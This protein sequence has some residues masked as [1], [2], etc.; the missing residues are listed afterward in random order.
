MKKLLVPVDFSEF[1]EYA[2]EV[3]ASLAKRHNAEISVF[4][5]LGISES[6]FVANE[7]A[8]MAEAKYYMNMAKDK[9]TT[10]LNKDYLKGIKITE[11]IQNYKVFSEIN[12]LAKEMDID[13]I[14]MGSHGS[15][16]LSEFFVGS[17]TEKVVR[18]SSVPVL[19]I[20]QR[21][22]DF[23]LEK[24]VFACD[25]KIENL[26]AFIHA[27]KLFS[28][29]EAKINLVYVNRPSEYFITKA[30]L[31]ERIAYFMSKVRDQNLENIEVD[32]VTDYSIEHGILAYCKKI[33]ADLV[34]IPTHGR[35]GWAHFFV[36]SLGENIANHAHMPV[37]TFRI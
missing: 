21:R 5:M 4:H 34:A 15:K 1:S 37:M 22:P 29:Q 31:D 11:V 33:H 18:T 20:K 17:N 28:E 2:L 30:E 12:E 27:V 25:F 9:F 7:A 23:K 26:Y 8:E 36:G 13:L 32:Y 24:V 6:V 16:G 35:K 19:V 10:F 3:A 14:I